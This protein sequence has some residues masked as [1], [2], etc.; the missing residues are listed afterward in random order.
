MR[1][2]LVWMW[3]LIALCVMALVVVR[4]T[5][6]G[7][8]FKN[9]PMVN[10]IMTLGKKS[11][12]IFHPQV[13]TLSNGL[14][15]IVVENHRAPLVNHIIWYR[16]G[17]ADEEGG[18]TG[19]AHF[20]EH[21]MFGPTLT[22]PRGEYF[23]DIESVG[24]TMNAFT[25]DDY[26]AYYASVAK[27]HL[28]FVMQL[29]ADR[30]KNIQFEQGFFDSEKKVILEEWNFR[31]GD[32]PEQKFNSQFLPTLFK[33]H[34][35]GREIIGLKADIAA[36]TMDDAKAFHEKW[37]APNNAILVVSGDV[38]AEEVFSMAQNVYGMIEAKEIPTRSRTLPDPL[39][40][41]F[42][43]TYEDPLQTQSKIDLAYLVPSEPQDLKAGLSLAILEEIMNE[44]S[45]TFYDSMVKQEKWLLD[46]SVGYD[47]GREDSTTFEFVMTL[48][49]GKRPED[50]TRA[51]KEKLAQL[52]K[53]GVS[54]STFQDAK[55]RLIASVD[56]ARDGLMYPGQIFGRSLCVGQT[57][58]D[59]EDWPAELDRITLSDVNEALVTFFGPNIHY[60]VGYILPQANQ[61]TE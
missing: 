33:T 21:L 37:Y 9:F 14:Q 42:T 55:K 56:Y 34:P 16:V 59:V 32:N 24:G 17:S 31:I 25:S 41:N 2:G 15:V 12:G 19:I 53:D 1:K 38:V 57:I 18:K 43:V 46:F 11:S 58:D 20:L 35:Y 48:V 23:R 28:Q 50:A 51:F 4:F 39:L 40:A 27:D 61:K 13:K 3:I 30:L 49:D 60:S 26:T 29:E 54:K 47:A 45:F 36:L 7:S 6:Y 10:K 44:K 22:K 8:K 5:P 52:V